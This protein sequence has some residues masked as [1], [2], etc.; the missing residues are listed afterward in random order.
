MK[1][2]DKQFYQTLKKDLPCGLW[3]H[4]DEPL[5]LIEASD[6]TRKSAQKQG[7]ADRTLVHA[8][9]QTD[10]GEV[11]AAANAISLFAEKAFI[12]IRLPSAKPVPAVQKALLS[13]FDNPNP[14]SFVFISGPK[15]DNGFCKTKT[16]KTL[17]A[18]ID[19]ALFWPID[20]QHLP[21][22]LQQRASKLSLTLEPDA[23]QLLCDN[24]E[25]NLLAAQQQ[26]EHLKLLNDDSTIT[27]AAMQDVISTNARFD[28]FGTLE[29]ALMGD[30]SGCLRAL[31]GLQQEGLAPANI[32]WGFTREIQ[33]LTKIRQD[34]KNLGAEQAL[35]QN[36]VWRRQEPMYRQ[37]LNRLKTPS[38]LK[39]MQ[40]CQLLDTQ[41]KGQAAGN[42]WDTMAELVMLM[43]GKPMPTPP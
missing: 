43:G 42:A 24:V 6:A 36:G 1:L 15:L 21:Q 14:D 18:A 4:S 26:L 2:N 27:I 7:F 31:Q 39:A 34:A 25:G 12:E 8:D 16:Y 3:I 9:N 28:V 41:S 13:Y 35:K 32:S 22:W 19:I 40:L 20:S 11:F 10:W 17:E 37:A 29:K 33:K 38:L 30:I 23:L 5:L